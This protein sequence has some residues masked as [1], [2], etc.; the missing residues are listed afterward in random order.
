MAYNTGTITSAD[1]AAD[2]ITAIEAVLDAHSGQGE[3]VETVA[4]SSVNYRVWKNRGSGVTNP[5]SWGS[6]YYFS[7]NRQSATEIRI[8]VFES[9]DATNKKAIR[10]CRQSTTAA[11][12]NANFSFGDETSGFTL[13]SFGAGATGLT[14]TGAIGL[15]TTGFTWYFQATKDRVYF[16]IRQGTTDDAFSFGVFESLL[17]TSPSEA[18]PLYMQAGSTITAGNMASSAG[19]WSRHPGVPIV[20]SASNW[21]GSPLSASLSP[22]MGGVGASASVDRFHNN[23]WLIARPLV[24][25]S[26]GGVS[27]GS[28]YGFYRGLIYDAVRLAND[29]GTTRNGDTVTIS[30]D[31]YVKISGGGWNNWIKRDAT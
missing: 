20:S 13:N 8:T 5:N 27:D 21:R 6:D 9:W 26:G 17:T 1:P 4:I 15:V 29:G 22:V 14:Y 12:P 30:G 3:F 10:P 11:T 25:A 7:I 2:L 31:V 23:S 16:G 28:T 19:A 18:F 24:S